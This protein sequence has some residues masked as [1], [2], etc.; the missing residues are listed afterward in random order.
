MKYKKLISRALAVI[1]GIMLVVFGTVGVLADNDESSGGEEPVQTEQSDLEPETLAPEPETAEPEPETLAPEP[2]PETEETVTEYVAPET[3]QR[4][5]ETTVAEQETQEIINRV[6]NSN[7]GATE[8]FVP[9][10][11]PKTVSQKSYTTNYA[12]GITSWI[13]VAVG[14]IVIIS[15]LVSTKASGRRNN[16]GI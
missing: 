2:E 4:Q 7:T 6:D 13:C 16:Q 12:F 9:P 11:V 10:T 8:F 3:E 1:F 5:E 14:T 15:V